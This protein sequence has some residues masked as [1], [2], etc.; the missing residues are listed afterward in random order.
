MNGWMDEWM[1]G[2]I[3][4]STSRADLNKMLMSMSVGPFCDMAQVGE[5]ANKNN[6][7]IEESRLLGRGFWCFVPN[8]FFLLNSYVSDLDK[9]I[10]MHFV[11]KKEIEKNRTSHIKKILYN[12]LSALCMQRD[13]KIVNIVKQTAETTSPEPFSWIPLKFICMY[14]SWFHIK[15]NWSVHSSNGNRDLP[16]FFS[17]IDAVVPYDY[18]LNICNYSK[19]AT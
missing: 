14:Y 5:G 15:D 4:V 3:Y 1:N 6:S 7:P 19:P 12:V 8:Y 9:S 11:F 17:T 10:D 18:A 13:R 16:L 2:W